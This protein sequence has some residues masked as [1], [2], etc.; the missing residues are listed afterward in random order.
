MPARKVT[1]SASFTKI[2]G[3]YADCPKDDTCPIW[4]YT[5]ASVTAWYHDGVH[6]CIENSVTS[7]YGNY[8][9]G[10]DDDTSRAM[11]ATI[12]WRLE[13]SPVVNYIL[14]FDD[15][16][17]GAWHTEAVRWA[18][19]SGVVNGYGNRKFGPGDPITREQLA[20]MLYRYEQYKG[21]G[22]M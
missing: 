6:Y 20:A 16:A 21:G 3:D 1:V 19:A 2:R 18:A 10:P 17:E 13:S 15:V 4:P 12:L 14:P 9:F 8:T 7:G 11:I 22:I 5:D